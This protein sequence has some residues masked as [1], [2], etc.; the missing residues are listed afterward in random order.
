MERCD[1]LNLVL[2]STGVFTEYKDG[3]LYVWSVS[4]GTAFVTMTAY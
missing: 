1:L 4:V 2:K 3:T